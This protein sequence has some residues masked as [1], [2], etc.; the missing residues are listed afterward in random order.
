MYHVSNIKD[1]SSRNSRRPGS[2]I[3]DVIAGAFSALYRKTANASEHIMLS[4]LEPIA[5]VNSLS[6]VAEHINLERDPNSSQY[7][8]KYNFNFALNQYKPTTKMTR[9]LLTGGS[10]FL[11]THVLDTL[12]KRGY[13]FT[14]RYLRSLN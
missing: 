4:N 10:G 11:A 7:T 6:H 1:A 3:N 5:V 13:A 14:F 8:F 12:L 9:V 2:M